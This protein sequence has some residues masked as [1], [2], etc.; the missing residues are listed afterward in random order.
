[1]GERRKSK[2]KIRKCGYGEREMAVV[3]CLQFFGVLL[4]A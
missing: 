4:S 3:E 2:K 1:M